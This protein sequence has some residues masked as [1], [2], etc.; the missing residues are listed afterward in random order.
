M[1]VSIHQPNYFPWLGLIHKI[2]LCDIFVVLDDVQANKASNQYRNIFYC[3]GTAKYLTLPVNYKL[4][5]KINELEF[6]N[7]EWRKDHL[8]KLKSYYGKSPNFR[9]IYSEL[10][11]IYLNPNNDIPIKL[12]ISSIKYLLI[13]FNLEH[14]SL[15]LS[16][17]LNT[18]ENKG[19]LVVEICKKT[20]ATSYVSGIGAKSYLTEKHFQ[21]LEEN[22]IKLIWQNFKHSIYAQ[23]NNQNFVE[24]LSALDVLFWQKDEF[25][26]ELFSKNR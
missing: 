26:K 9:E 12:L 18:K 16:S 2:S 19:D 1:I 10:E 8:N 15:V 3:N 21:Y 6:T 25:I 11:E 4:N 17:S 5:I 24:G 14:V 22:K 23:A 13:K 7:N 20:N